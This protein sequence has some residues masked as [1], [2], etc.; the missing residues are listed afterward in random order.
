MEHDRVSMRQAVRHAR[1]DL[2]RAYAAGTAR[3]LRRIG[4]DGLAMAIRAWRRVRAA[5]RM[6][7]LASTRV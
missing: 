6:H 1:A 5:A 2:M 4:R 3:G 7:G